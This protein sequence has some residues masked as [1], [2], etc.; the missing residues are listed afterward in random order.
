MCLSITA[1]TTLLLSG[2]T[3]SSC[4]IAMICGVSAG[5]RPPG[6]EREAHTQSGAGQFAGEQ[7]YQ[8]GQAQDAIASARIT[9]R[10]IKVDIFVVFIICRERSQAGSERVRRINLGN[11]GRISEFRLYDDDCDFL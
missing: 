6:G 1:L 9:N 11:I 7:L 8:L 10:R 5:A 2:F 4:V 3:A